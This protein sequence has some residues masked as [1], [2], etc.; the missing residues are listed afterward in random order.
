MTHPV[1]Y[2]IA[3]SQFPDLLPLLAAGHGSVGAAKRRN[4]PEEGSVEMATSITR[5][6]RAGKVA[7]DMAMVQKD[8][9]LMG[10]V[11][12]SCK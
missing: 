1:P 3:G 9:V 2:A 6:M 11:M 4:R 10:D 7:R 8:G 5:G 12:K